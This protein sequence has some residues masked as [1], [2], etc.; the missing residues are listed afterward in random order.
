MKRKLLFLLVF[1]YIVFSLS[2]QG[3][4]K[5]RYIADSLYRFRQYPEALGYYKNLLPDIAKRKDLYKIAVCYGCMEQRDSSVYYFNRALEKGF[6]YPSGFGLE[7]DKN[8]SF[9]REGA[10]YEV[11][12]NKL[13]ENRLQYIHVKDSVL[14]RELIT[15]KELDQFYRHAISR[16]QKSDSTDTPLYLHY[17][18][19]SR[20]SDSL[21]MLFLDSLLNQYGCWLGLDLV[22]WDGDEAAWVIA[23][24]ADNFVGFQEKCLRFLQE[25][26]QQENTN[27]HNV[28]YLYDRIQINKGGHQRYGTQM[29][30]IDN[31]V[32]FIRLED[33]H[34][35]EYY[36]A[37][38]QL[39]PVYIYKK[40]LEGRYL[41]NE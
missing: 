35:L 7:Q 2:G 23:Q 30:I 36:R 9:L 16:M 19:E 5:E 14:Y 37:C 26:D 28:A 22:G 18:A 8:L 4:C 40:A 1:L 3:Y 13:N 39:P 12:L 24:H 32:D 11:Y 21:H 31:K 25:A 38:Y 17:L 27:P 6:Y 34:H 10:G 29:R 33:E 20:K 41:K 15:Q